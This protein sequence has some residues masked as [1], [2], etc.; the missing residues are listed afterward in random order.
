M[1]PKAWELKE[2][3]ETAYGSE[4]ERVDSREVR[5]LPFE[6]QWQLIRQLVD[7]GPRGTRDN[8]SS[9]EPAIPG[10]RKSPGDL[11]REI[12]RLHTEVGSALGNHW[13]HLD[14]DWESIAH[15]VR[16]WLN[17]VAEVQVGRV[18]SGVVNYL[19]H[20]TS[21]RGNGSAVR[22]WQTQSEVLRDALD[23]Y[24]G[25]VSDLQSALEMDNQLRF[26]NPEG[27]TPLPFSE[28]RHVLSKWESDLVRIQDL[29]AF[30][31]GADAALQEGL[32]AVVTVAAKNQKAATF[33]TKWFERAWYENIVETAFSER[34]ALRNFDGNLHEVRIQRFRPPTA[35]HWTTIEPEW[36]PPTSA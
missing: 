21:E 15:A 4:P 34:A 13:N 23:G 32:H 22:S 30:N 31:A 16:W 17:L 14:T 24:P 9:E 18:T 7:S 11:A 2:L 5:H 27:L 19:R 29:A 12:V 8:S 33:L 6:R 36:P 10:P 35:S 1:K 26:R 3:L 20:L 25:S 28:Q